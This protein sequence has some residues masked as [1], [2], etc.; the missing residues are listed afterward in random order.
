[1]CLSWLWLNSSLVKLSL[2]HISSRF[3]SSSLVSLASYSRTVAIYGCKYYTTSGLYIVKSAAPSC[4]ILNIGTSLCYEF[5]KLCLFAS[6]SKRIWI[7]FLLNS[8]LIVG[9]L[10]ILNCASIIATTVF[11][12]KLSCSS[13]DTT[14]CLIMSFSLV[15][16]LYTPKT[17]VTGRT[18]PTRPILK[19]FA[20]D[21]SRNNLVN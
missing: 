9:T 15:T 13:Y 18:T 10:P 20:L 8:S 21:E 17:A 14:I 7:R 19:I 2:A 1:M 5:V 3:N 4:N 6:I 16:Y 12:S 11:K